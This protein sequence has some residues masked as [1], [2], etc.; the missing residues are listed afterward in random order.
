M[1]TRELNDN[2]L[3][4]NIADE[5]GRK[6]LVPSSKIARRFQL[7]SLV[8]FI[9]EK[10]G[11]TR[12]GSVLEI[13]CGPGASSE[14]LRGMY[15]SYVGV[16][17][18]EEFIKHAREN[19]AYPGVEFL[20]GNVKEL[21]MVNAPDLVLGVGVLHH[22]T[23]IDTALRELKSLGGPGTVYAFIEPNSGNPVIQ[24]LRWIRKKTDTSYSSDQVYFTRKELADMFGRNGFGKPAFKYEGYFSPPFAQV[25]LNPQAVFKT[26]SSVSVAADNFI[27]RHFNL[28]LSWNIMMVVGL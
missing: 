8:D 20:C 9:G 1:N 17:Y 4:N 12:F 18:S 15:K 10:F 13:G 11:I 5:Y 28:A 23:E 24:S 27:Q 22:I 6:D 16:D 25:I 26:V 3:F 14:Y 2:N 19:Y 21:K 7:M